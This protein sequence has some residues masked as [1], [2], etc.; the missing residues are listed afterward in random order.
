M[1]W[2]MWPC[3]RHHIILEL[4]LLFSSSWPESVLSLL[5][6]CLYPGNLSPHQFGLQ[7]SICS[8]FCLPWHPFFLSFPHVSLLF[9]L[10]LLPLHSFDF[11]SFLILLFM[12]FFSPC[13][14][15]CH[16]PLAKSEID[17]LQGCLNSCPKQVC[18]ALA[19]T[20]MS[21]CYVGLWDHITLCLHLIWKCP[22]YFHLWFGVRPK[23]I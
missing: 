16:S 7:V 20:V 4:F 8:F 15:F 18:K 11:L 22:S 14:L 13:L 19:V 5:L 1:W 10:H 21:I 12:L 17:C 3:Q 2:T 9:N 6:S 23:F